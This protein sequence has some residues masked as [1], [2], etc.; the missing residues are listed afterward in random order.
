[1]SQDSFNLS[2]SIYQKSQEK[3]SHRD[4]HNTPENMLELN[5]HYQIPPFS[6]VL[7]ENQNICKNLKQLRM[8]TSDEKDKYRYDRSTIPY[9]NKNETSSMEKYPRA[10]QQQYNTETSDDRLERRYAEQLNECLNSGYESYQNFK[11]PSQV[12]SFELTNL[13]GGGFFTE[14]ENLHPNHL[15]EIKTQLNFRP[16]E[17]NQ[18]VV[19][20]KITG[21][22]SASPDN[23]AMSKSTTCH[24]SFSQ[25]PSQQPYSK[26]KSS[27]FHQ[28]KRKNV[29]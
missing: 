12:S 7:G 17:L 4:P 3:R 20:S 13:K 29:A 18:S 5:N 27:Q 22:Y 24:L 9:N 28:Q 15:N 19:G 2:A 11:E 8:Q 10:H 25:Y 23:R 16:R 14:K 6:E 1:M 26:L 21:S